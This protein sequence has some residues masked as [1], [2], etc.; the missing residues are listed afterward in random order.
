MGLCL[1]R[2]IGERILIGDDI[3]VRLVSVRGKTAKIS[4]EAPRGVRID[5]EEV[6]RRIDAEQGG[7]YVSPGA[8]RA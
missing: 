4:I 3:E 2:K 5:R 8:G 1:E 6:R 7:T